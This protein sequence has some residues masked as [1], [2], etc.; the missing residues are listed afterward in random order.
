MTVLGNKISRQQI[1]EAL[2]VAVSSSVFLPIGLS[3]LII[4]L[5]ALNFLFDRNL[6][7][8]LQQLLT[9]KL[10]LLVMGLFVIQ[11]FSALISQNSHVAFLVVE[12]RLS[13]LLF[14]LL[15]LGHSSGSTIKKVSLSFVFACQVSILICLGGA[16]VLFIH[17]NDWGVFFYHNLSSI[18]GLNAIYLSIY[19]SFSLFVLLYYYKNFSIVERRISLVSMVFL[20][21][22]LVLLSSKM[23]LFGTLIGVVL[24]LVWKLRSR[25]HKGLIF[26]GAMIFCAL[27]LILKPVRQRFQIEFNSNTEVLKLNQ[28]RYDTPFT[29]LTLRLVIW[30]FCYE[31][32]NEKRAWISGVGVGDFQDLL[33][34]KYTE[35][36]LYIGNKQL[37][38]TGY[39]GYGPHNQWVETF[40]S[41]GLLGLLYFIFLVSFVFNHYKKQ[42][43][44]LSILFFMIFILVSFTECVLSTNK[45]IVFF[46]F[47]ICL[48]NGYNCRTISSNDRNE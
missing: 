35:R 43:N 32:I 45:G 46:A 14:P 28:Y 33:N 16:F 7:I 10:A 17:S 22:G 13:F 3:S 48:F 12:R 40:I 31:I 4:I 34:Q 8:K 5:A 42:G 27:I 20:M 1:D 6:N 11:I 9:N 23:L 24:Y 29:G 2:L 47:F 25:Y 30:K 26:S 37:G 39:I 36:G 38:D 44:V 21:F 19:C 18:L 15:L 41:M